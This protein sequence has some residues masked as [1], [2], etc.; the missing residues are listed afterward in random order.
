MKMPEFLISPER[1]SIIHDLV[2]KLPG[3]RRKVHLSQE[4]LAH[5]VGKS[6]QKISDIERMTAPMGWDTYIAVCVALE[7]AGVFNEETDSWYFY[8]KNRWFK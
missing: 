8:V 3:L 2:E 5:M 1:E 6:R 7:A 4:E